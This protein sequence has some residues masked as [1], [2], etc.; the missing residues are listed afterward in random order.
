MELKGQYSFDNLELESNVREVYASGIEKI[1]QADDF[2]SCLEAIN[3][4]F[5]ALNNSH[6][7]LGRGV[8]WTIDMI[9]AYRTLGKI[10]GEVIESHHEETKDIRQLRTQM[11]CL[12]KAFF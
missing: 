7:P 1:R 8:D 3:G 12:E 10:F 2:G 4:I 6:P 9:S 11:E 5:R